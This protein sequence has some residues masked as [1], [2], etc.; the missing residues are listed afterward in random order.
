MKYEEV[1]K[2]Q[3]EENETYVDEVN[4]TQRKA[5]LEFEATAHEVEK[6]WRKIQHEAALKAFRVITC[7]ILY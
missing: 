5:F 3:K 6:K 7:L 4:E 1:I 2:L